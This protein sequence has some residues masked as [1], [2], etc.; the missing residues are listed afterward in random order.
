MSKKQRIPA[1]IR[2]AQD[3]KAEYDDVEVGP[4]TASFAGGAIALDFGA[5][6]IY[7]QELGIVEIISDFTLK[8][9]IIAKIKH[10]IVRLES[11]RV[12]QVHTK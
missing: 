9:E 12:A 5:R 2:A 10:L 11:Q 4:G 6:L 7:C 1:I 3:L 8:T